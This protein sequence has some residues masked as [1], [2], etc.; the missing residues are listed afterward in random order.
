MSG[1]EPAWTGL[2]PGERPFQET[3]WFYAE[4]RYR[5]TAGFVR[6]LSTHLEW[7]DSDRVLDLGAGPAHL[8]IPLSAFLGEV[9]VM[10]P[11]QSMLTEGRR[12]AAAAGVENLSFIPGGSDDLIRLAPTLGNFAAAVISQAFHWMTDQDAVLRSLSDL[13]DSER[14]AVAL[15]GYVKEPDYNLVWLNRPPWNAVEAILRRHLSGVPEGPRP[16][17]RH[18][19]FPA[20][21]ARSAFSRTE[22]LTYEYEAVLYPSVEAAIGFHYSVGNVLHR[23]GDRRTAFEAEVRAALADADTRPVRARLVDSSLI[24]RRP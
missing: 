6:L 1:R 10:D 21:L 24:G 7:S 22:L 14:G 19:L 9:V 15:V 13:L 18:D 2:K 5:P 4:Y 12:R 16:A 17:G 8:S 23:L 20:I 11:E 3:S